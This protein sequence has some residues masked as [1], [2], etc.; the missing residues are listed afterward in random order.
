MISPVTILKRG[1]S[2]TTNFEGKV[3]K[4]SE[5]IDIGERLKVKLS[6]GRLL[7]KVYNKT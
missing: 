1:Y 3:I 6:R 2:I 4:D 5:L 7:T